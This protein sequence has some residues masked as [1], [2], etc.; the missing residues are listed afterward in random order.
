LQ[1]EFVHAF[2][3]DFDFNVWIKPKEE[4]AEERHFF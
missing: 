1:Y 4:R 3:L 2:F